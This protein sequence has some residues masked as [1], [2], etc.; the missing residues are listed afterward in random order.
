MKKFNLMAYDIACH[1]SQDHAVAATQ[2]VA[3]AFIRTDTTYDVAW[4]L[5]DGRIVALDISRGGGCP[6]CGDGA[7]DQSWYVLTPKAP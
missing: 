7:G 2:G 4:E 5:A 1:D 6:T 3:I